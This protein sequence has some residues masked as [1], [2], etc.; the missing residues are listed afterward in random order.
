MSAMPAWRNERRRPVLVLPQPSSKLAV[1]VLLSTT[2]VFIGDIITPL[3]FAEA[4]LYLLPLLLSSFLYDPRLP[5]RLAGASTILIAAGFVLSPPGAPVAY[6]ILNRT[7]AVI[8]LWTAAFG[9]RRLIQDRIAHLQEEQ[10]WQLLAHQTNDILWDWDLRTDAHWWSDN[11]TATFGYDPVQEPSIVAWQSRLHPD[12]QIR[13]H[14]SLQSAIDSGQSGWSSE[15]RFRM[16]DGSYRTFLDRGAILRHESGTAI[17]MIGAMIDVTVHKQSEAALQLSN[18]RF[19]DLVENLHGVVWEAEAG[20]MA[21]R[22]VSPHAEKFLGYPVRQWLD[23]PDFWP[24]HIHPADRDAT[25]ARCLAATAQG[26]AHSAEY[27]MI[28]ADGRVV[29]VHDVVTVAAEAGT[30]K[31]VQGVLVDITRRKQAEQALQ[32]LVL[33]TASVTGSEFFPQ[34]VRHMAQAL[35]VSHA[36][37]AEVPTGNR[38]RARTLAVWARNRHGENFEYDLAGTPFAGVVGNTLCLY[39]ERVRELFPHDRILHTMEAESY[40][41]IPLWSSSGQ[42]IG[43]LAVLDDKPSH[44]Q[45]DMEPLLTIFA[46]RASAELERIWT[47]RSMRE[48]ELAVR[49]LYDITSSSSHSFEG[50]VDAILDLG[51]RHFN[52]PI[53]ILTHVLGDQTE[54]KIVRASGLD[55]PVGTCVPFHGSP[56]ERAIVQQESLDVPDLPRSRFAEHVISAGLGLRSYFGTGVCVQDHTY[57]TVCFLSPEAAAPRA[58]ADKIFLQLMARWISTALERE[59]TLAA[60]R[61][62]EERKSAILHAAL[63][64][65]VTID[66]EERI[67]EFNPAAE[68]IFGYAREAV[69]GQRVDD[70]IIPPAL[71]E[72]HRLGMAHCLETGSGP[73]F[74][75]RVEI[76]ALRA[77]GSEFPIE[78]SLTRIEGQHPPLFTAFIRDLT[79]RKKSETALLESEA[80]F[81]Q[82]AESITEVFWLTTPEKGT[83][84]Y[85]SPAYEAVWGKSCQSLYSNPASWLE[86]I[87]PDDRPRIAAAM[88]HTQTEGRYC[89]QYRIIRPDGTIRWIEDRAF[90]VKD[91][92]GR[93]ARIAGVAQDI[94]DRIE[95][96][97]SLRSSE[98]RLREA[99]QIAGIG[100]WQWNTTSEVTWSDETYRIFGY[101]PQSIIPSYD[102]F[103]RTLHA[104]DRTGMIAALRATMSEDALFDIVCRILRP[105]GEQ[106]YIHCRGA[107]TRN[108]AG[109]PVRMVG[110]VEDVTDRKRADDRLRLAYEQ[111]QE[112]TRHAAAAEENERRRIAREIHDELGQLL[113][114][115]RFQL[116]S[117]K[118]QRGANAARD[119]TRDR[120]SRLNDL[121]DLSDSMLNQVRHLS[122]SLRPAI[123]D[124]L[125]LIPAVQAHARQFEIRTGIACDVVVDP[126]LTDC[127]FD[128][129]TSSS[130]FRIIQELL[131]NVLRHAQA[132]AVAVSFAAEGP[133]LTVTVHDNGS[134]IAP[135]QERHHNSFGLKGISE[136]AALLGG[137][138]AIG[139]SPAEGTVATLRIPMSVLSLTPLPPPPHQEDHENPVGR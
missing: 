23:E 136:R 11:A 15:Y 131:T 81:R 107:I 52:Y 31:T 133:T 63:D 80:R 30:P 112:V 38:L 26:L 37:V 97:T 126:A 101:V 100:S 92:A 87:H 28:A 40:M 108:D 71:R 123:L 67:I 55:I 127:P 35:N 62:S 13:I 115:M 114:A 99:Q 16:H 18:Q 96:E 109:L 34:L 51:R 88:Q 49:E 14:T 90:P 110:T 70:L 22:L 120:D 50:Q 61:S 93:I 42:P 95:A 48:H 45:Q 84:L 68:I 8:M 4:I 65:I 105:S 27:R 113:T 60:L 69:L 134:G 130:V 56:C 74:D 89:E 139:P 24:N 43:L 46:A 124:E 86:A 138:F 106:R 76:T 102:L 33:A 53:G 116:T 132:M 6:A 5:I 72:R 17:R 47:D 91:H 7:L 111:L 122:T 57:G 83:M 1:S 85:V 25:V 119:Q 104:D 117:L 129:A 44:A 66:A 98:T 64:G 73:F 39:P 125:G 118:K 135:E 78:L 77:D 54:L 82:L 21:F 2:V 103:L 32:T 3:G 94:T 137:T 121:L 59:E 128:D 9:L 10:R 58:E 12:D 36:L 79:E 41:G 75:R 29:W 19:A 20:S